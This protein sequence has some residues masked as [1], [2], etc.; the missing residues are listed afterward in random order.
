MRQQ[1]GALPVRRTG[2]ELRVLLVTSRE[3][4]RWIIPKG[5]RMRGRSDGEAAAQEAFEEAGVRGRVRTKPIGRYTYAKR[6]TDGVKDCRITIY[7]LEVTDEFDTFPEM[8]DRSRAW[9]TIAEATACADDEGLRDLLRDLAP[10]LQ[11]MG[12]SEGKAA[13]KRAKAAGR[14]TSSGQTPSG[15]ATSG[16]AAQPTSPVSEASR[17]ETAGADAA[18]RGEPPPSDQ[19]SPFEVS[20]IEA[21]PI[22]ASAAETPPGAASAGKQRRGGGSGGK[23]AVGKTAVGKTAGGKTAGGKASRGKAAAAKATIRKAARKALAAASLTS[24]PQAAE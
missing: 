13:R 23:A 18:A 11:E 8:A 14:Q 17:T 5:W 20:P 1:V 24:S 15:M 3:T 22:E 6:L 10:R 21:P 12:T 16:D 19:T 7:L 9:F 4:Q 2:D